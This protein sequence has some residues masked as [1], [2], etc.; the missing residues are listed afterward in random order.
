MILYD[1]KY[2]YERILYR[3][4]I[5]TY[6]L[7]KIKGE[8][9]DFC[10]YIFSKPKHSQMAIKKLRFLLTRI[11]LRTASIAGD[12]LQK[13]RL[14]FVCFFHICINSCK[15]RLK[16]FLFMIRKFIEGFIF[17][18]TDALCQNFVHSFTFIRNLDTS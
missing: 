5:I 8:T 2:P 15:H 10:Q 17:N 12:F 18:I 6:Q 3:A 13:T 16:C 1:T 9:F 11:L 14:S 7:Y 4:L